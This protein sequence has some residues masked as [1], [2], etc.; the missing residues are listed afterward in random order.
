MR[1][2]R[3]L[4]ALLLCLLLPATAQ[5]LSLQPIGNF[6]RPI[7]VTSDPGKPDRLFVV[8][9]PGRIKVSEGGSVTTFADLRS[10]VGCP[11]S[12]VCSGERGLLSI[13]LA[14][15]FASSGRFYVDYAQN[16]TG[17]IHVAELVAIGGSALGVVPRD[18]L[19][20]P[21][22]KSRTTTAVS[23]NSAPKA[24]SSSRPATAAAKTTSTTTR[25]T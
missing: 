7:Y 15:D 20:I 21:T 13:A 17:V 3:T 9:R 14:P 19:A 8:E 11:A 24:T 22:R 6:E 23:C 2:S 5:A 12:G 18:L 16:S 10:I 4:G 1:L 25:R